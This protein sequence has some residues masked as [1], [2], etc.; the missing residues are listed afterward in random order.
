[1]V[2]IAEFCACFSSLIMTGTQYN[3]NN[4]N[5]IKEHHEVLTSSTL[6]I[7]LNIAQD[8]N[9]KK[10]QKSVSV[11]RKIKN[12]FLTDNMVLNNDSK[13]RLGFQQK[14]LLFNIILV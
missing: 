13:V 4:N 7:R 6:N 1:M 10:F 2:V 14:L 9:D 12:F 5:N 8:K 3:N 11:N